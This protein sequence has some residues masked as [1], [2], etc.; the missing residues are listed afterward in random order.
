[1]ALAQS[2]L[3]AVKSTTACAGLA[4]DGPLGGG[5]GRPVRSVEVLILGGGLCGMSAAIGLGR[6]G[7]DDVVIVERAAKFGGTWFHNR[8]PGCAVDIPSHA[9]SFS[10]ALRPDWSRVFALQPELEAYLD[11]VAREYGLGE[12]LQASTEV[13]DARWDD[14]AQRWMITTTGGSYSARSFVIA[15]GPLHEPV[16]PGLPGLDSFR[17]EM[18][19][20]THWPDGIEL[21]GKRVV[22]IG[23]GASAVQFVPAIQPQVAQLTVLQ[24]TAS[25]VLPKVDWKVS[26]FEKALLRVFPPLRHLSRWV[27]WGVMDPFFTLTVHHPRFARVMQAFGR[28]NIRRAIR[29]PALREKL[30]PSYTATCKRIG[31]SNEFYPALAQPNVEVVTSGAAE[32]RERSVVTADGRE[33]AADLIIFGTGFQTLPHHPV[34]ERVRGRDGRSLAEVWDGCPQAYLGTTIAGFPN[35]FM[36]FGPNIGTLSGFVMAEAQTDYLVGAITAMREAGLSSIDVRPEEQAAF[37]RE[38]D[39]AAKGSTFLSGCQSYYLDDRGRV[40]LVWPWSMTRLRARLK[41][42]DLAAY[43][44]RAAAQVTA[45]R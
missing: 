20:S 7:V 8:Y 36:M 3:D 19:H 38:V 1:M 43:S 29:D 24:R 45:D 14:G 9:Y 10:F 40:A 39:E 26:S 28:F 12:K 22:V 23:T 37:V 16:V 13:T 17:G 21:A 18:F 32:I 30:T 27:M 6:A 41:R 25:W 2:D 4:Q 11:D 5:G 42:F 33:F 34:T 15:A 31:L 44:T 35:A